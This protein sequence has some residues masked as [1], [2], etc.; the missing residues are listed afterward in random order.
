MLKLLM[1]GQPYCVHGYK[2]NKGNTKYNSATV[3]SVSPLINHTMFNTAANARV[4][5]FASPA[6]TIGIYFY[7]GTGS[8]F[9]PMQF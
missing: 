1:P 4:V 8:Y 9:V 3:P 2:R 5:K 6:N 7:R